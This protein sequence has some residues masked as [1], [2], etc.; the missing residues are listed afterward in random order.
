M[1]VN[2]HKDFW[3]VIKPVS[4]SLVSVHSYAQNVKR[5]STDPWEGCLLAID[6]AKC[7]KCG[8][9]FDRN[10]SA[11]GYRMSMLWF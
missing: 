4:C 9:Y 5:H 11:V 1:D 2:M 7:G 8:D 3:F 10:Q 6:T